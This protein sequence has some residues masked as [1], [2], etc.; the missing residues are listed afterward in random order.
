[1]FQITLTI[2]SVVSKDE[3]ESTTGVDLR[4]LAPMGANPFEGTIV[5]ASETGI[6]LALFQFLAGV[7]AGL[8]DRMQIEQISQDRSFSEYTQYVKDTYDR[9][10]AESV[11]SREPKN[12]DWN[13][14][15]RKIV[16]R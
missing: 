4:V 13:E 11:A 6:A 12:T 7:L 5:H 9:L 15:F 1:M 8:D 3:S 10:I 14:V 2:D 16:N